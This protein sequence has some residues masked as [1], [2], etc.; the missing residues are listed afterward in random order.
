MSTNN[1]TQVQNTLAEINRNSNSG[2]GIVFDPQ[3]D[4]LK[5]M[6]PAANAP[7]NTTMITSIA[8]DG[9]ALNTPVVYAY[10]Q[11]VT[12]FIEN[13][14]PLKRGAAFGWQ[15]ENV[16]HVH[17]DF[18]KTPFSGIPCIAIFAKVSKEE[19]I[20]DKTTLANK[21]GI[22]NSS[23]NG[24]NKTI[25]YIFYFDGNTVQK[26]AFLVT[27]NSLTECC[28]QYVPQKSELFSRS[29]GLLETDVLEKKNVT[30]IGLG[31]F[32][33]NVTIELA[34]AGIGHFK[35]FDFD[36]IELSNI[37]RHICGTNDLGRYKTHAIRDAILQKNP[38]AD[39]QTF[40]ININE[41]E[42]LLITE[43]KNTDII[44]CMTDENRSRSRINA[45]AI[46]YQKKAIYGRAVTRAEGGDVFRYIPEKTKPCFAC[47]IGKGLFD[48]QK[49]EISTTK[50]A[51]RDL[52]AYTN[53]ED[54][55]ALVQ[56]GLSSDI[57][58][59][60][61]LIVKLTLVELSKGLNCG[62][63][64]LEEDL[65]ADYYLWANRRENN[66]KNFPKMEYKANQLSILRWYGVRVDKDTDCP[67]CNEVT[68][69]LG[70]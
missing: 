35:L 51:D 30:V 25:F 33:S 68:I 6:N 12:E 9:W 36:R 28:F 59:I 29:K 10:E 2:K 62:L 11:E 3:T 1:P 38:F 27:D 60:C 20:S 37:S 58:P 44:L 53:A 43:I 7:P 63:T 39:V 69:Q 49:E 22:I 57:L 5:T 26:A 8:K 65:V 18:P 32:G 56:A 48:F 50:Q 14:N 21:L 17:V 31:S 67:A 45:L 15:D 4:E 34:K 54:R 70:F 41:H 61:N 52:P 55:D 19:F 23:D 42:E 16:Y 13:G 24:C 64:S 40:E 47:L 66:Y 46:K